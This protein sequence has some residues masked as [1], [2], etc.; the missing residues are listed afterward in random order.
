MSEAEVLNVHPINQTLLLLLDNQA[1]R[2]YFA[3]EGLDAGLFTL[4]PGAGCNSIQKIGEHLIGL[5]GFQLLLLGSELAKDMPEKSAAS[6]EELLSKLDAATALVRRAIESHDPEDWH[7]DPTGPR[8]GPWA[9]LPTLL[10]FVRPMNDF[11]NHLGAIRALRRI[12][13]N[14]AEKTQ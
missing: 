11:T 10:R 8:E 6:L 14:P 9:E 5:R 4:D 13:G 12:H 3:F 7:A 2:T 1:S